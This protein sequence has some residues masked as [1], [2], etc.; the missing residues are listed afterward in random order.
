MAKI[1]QSVET[2]TKAVRDQL[3][4]DLQELEASTRRQLADLSQDGAAPTV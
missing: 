4:K 2:A 3:A 1:A